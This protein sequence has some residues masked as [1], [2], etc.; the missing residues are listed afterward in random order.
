MNNREWLN[1][2]A[3]TSPF[4]LK[5]W[6]DAEHEGAERTETELTAS[7]ASVSD[8]LDGESYTLSDGAELHYGIEPCPFCGSKPEVSTTFDN[9]CGD[10]H[11]EIRCP[12]C[13]AQFV[14]VMDLEADALR[15]ALADWN[16]RVERK[17]TDAVRKLLERYESRIAKLQRELDTAYG[18]LEIAAKNESRL[19]SE[20]D[21]WRMRCGELL[22]AAHAMQGVADAWDEEVRDD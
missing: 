6:F 21:R 12:D 5:A 16:A 15:D 22:D 13:Y 1:S 9:V 7:V 4:E 3:H 10:W 20:R 14:S 18:A 19:E 11:A 17:P 2:L 8:V